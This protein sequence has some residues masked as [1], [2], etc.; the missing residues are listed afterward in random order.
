MIKL[1]KLL[2]KSLFL[3]PLLLLFVACGKKNDLSAES[4]ISAIIA[5]NEKII[6]FGHVS[7]LEMLNKAGVQKIPQIN[8][9]V[10]AQLALWQKG[11]DLERPI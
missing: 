5:K 8:L 10:G 6:S 9:F 11:V 3:L 2:L 7:P 4:A 1:M